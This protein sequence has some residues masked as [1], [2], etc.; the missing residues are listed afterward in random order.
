[1]KA[2]SIS[3]IKQELLNTPPKKVVELCLRLARF[4]KENKELLTFLLFDA[5]DEAGYV[6]SIKEEI[7]EHFL[8]LNTNNTY[9]IKKGLRKVVRQI[10]KYCKYINE[11]S[12]EVEMRIYFCSRLNASGIPYTKN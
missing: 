9:F 1:M 10:S 5:H 2:A 7:D 11:K 4:K 12:S 3:E 6:Q 8:Q